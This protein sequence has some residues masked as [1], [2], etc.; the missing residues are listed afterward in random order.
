M[1]LQC[2]E[3]FWGV[4]WEPEQPGGKVL[5]A[6]VTSRVKVLQAGEFVIPGQGRSWDGDLVN[7]SLDLG[8]VLDSGWLEILAHFGLPHPDVTHPEC[9]AGT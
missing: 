7:A 3:L 5:E 6:R 2:C 9:S 4:G 8:T 1:P